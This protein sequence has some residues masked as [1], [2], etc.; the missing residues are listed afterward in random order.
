MMLGTWVSLKSESELGGQVKERVREREGEIERM[1][2]RQ[3]KG[4][5]SKN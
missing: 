2:D 1:T 3:R 5:K 4:I